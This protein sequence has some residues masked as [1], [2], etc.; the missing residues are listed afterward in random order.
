MNNRS[1]VRRA[2]NLSLLLAGGV[3][4]SGPAG[5]SEQ[6]FE[7][8][9]G[10][11]SEAAI[12]QST[13]TAFYDMNNVVTIRVKMDA[14]KWNELKAQEPVGGRCN[15]DV[16]PS[17]DRFAWMATTSVQVSGTS[18]PAAAKTYT[19]AEIKKKSFCGSFSTT[20][21]SLKLKFGSSAET[22]LGTRYLTLNN[23]VQDPSYVR[24]AL[25]YRLFRMAGLPAARINFARVYVNDVLVD[26]GVFVNVE[27]IRE[28]FIQNPQNGFASTRGN[29]YE[30][31][32]DD[33]LASRVPFVDVESLSAFTNKKDLQLAAGEVGLGPANTRRVID[34]PQWIRMQAMES[35]LRHADGY[36]NNR[37]NTYLYNDVNAVADPLILAGHIK[38]KFIPWGLDQIL[39]PAPDQWWDFKFYN[40]G[41]VSNMVKNDPTMYG[42]LI[43]RIREYEESVFGRDKLVQHQAFI[44][45][46]QTKLA[47]I[48]AAPAAEIATVRRQL[49]LS[50]AAAM[51][52]SGIQPNESVYFLEK[53]T[54]DVFYASNSE[55]VSGRT[56]DYEV[57]H[58]P[59]AES[60]GAR[61]FVTLGSGGFRIGSEA[62]PAH[63][64]LHASNSLRSPAG[65]LLLY[66][67]P[68]DDTTGA[69]EFSFH[70]ERNVNGVQFSGYFRLKSNR[71]GLWLRY[72]SNA[73]RTPS[74]RL[75]VYQ[76]A[77][78][79]ASSLHFY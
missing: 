2:I 72:S 34:I 35:L 28:S 11:T 8:P 14:A 17:V 25:G 38:F 10:A 77:E 63:K 59:F 51:K 71:T 15:M 62:Y 41:L 33:F 24:Q 23:S 67:T 79:G 61:W 46:M 37:N 26:N 20:K 60:G 16:D 40:L 12:T 57:L 75:R 69:K 9:I 49:R 32:T 22:D 73:D 55:L 5:F 68:N 7:E 70:D 58:V 50:R 76:G 54:N 29:L 43:T 27:P 3:A 44:D 39:V 42:E 78:S 65:N 64:W 53:D 1:G 45:L 4:C 66:T 6:D 52:W 21:P 19:G 18:F 47:S 36:G 30:I 13:T 31:E 56:T 48:G 74:G